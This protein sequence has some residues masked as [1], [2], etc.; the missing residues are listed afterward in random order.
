MTIF[1]IFYRRILRQSLKNF[2]KYDKQ[3]FIKYKKENKLYLN[4]TPNYYKWNIQDEE[5]YTY[6]QSY[7]W[8]SIPWMLK[9]DLKNRKRLDN[10]I[11]LLSKINTLLINYDCDK[12]NFKEIPCPIGLD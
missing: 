5:A 4:Y 9:Q 2:E 6:G 8:L 1:K 7:P 12:D 11:V 10:D 3:N